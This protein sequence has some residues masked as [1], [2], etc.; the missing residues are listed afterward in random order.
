[1]QQKRKDAHGRELRDA[2]EMLQMANQKGL[3]IKLAD[4]GFEISEADIAC[5]QRWLNYRKQGYN[6]A[7]S[8]RMA[9]HAA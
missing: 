7:N 5:D 2:R 3:T 4:F 9:D 8:S 6:H 1:M